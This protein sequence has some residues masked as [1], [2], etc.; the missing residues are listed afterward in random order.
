MFDSSD[1]EKIIMFGRESCPYTVKMVDEL[2]R[3]KTK[4][5]F[6]FVD[7]ST[8]SG[9]KRFEKIGGN[10]VPHFL[11]KKKSATGYMPVKKLMEKLNYF[12]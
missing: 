2:K 7:T 4:K 6:E 10:G 12:S 9:A 8:Q 3:T 1:P 11:Y 5:H